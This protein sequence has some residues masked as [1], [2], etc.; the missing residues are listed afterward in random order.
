MFFA[1]PDF[2]KTAKNCPAKIAHR[3]SRNCTRTSGKFNRQN[4]PQA[5]GRW[6]LSLSLSPAH[7][8][9]T[10]LIIMACT[11]LSKPSQNPKACDTTEYKG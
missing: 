9:A 7:I 4:H 2:I 10:K 6:I 1:L 5:L 3:L 8:L 11:P